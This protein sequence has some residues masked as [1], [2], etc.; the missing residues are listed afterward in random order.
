MRAAD[1]MGGGVEE[2]TRVN[3]CALVGRRAGARGRG[4]RPAL[5][6]R[7]EE[8]DA[9]LADGALS[10]LTEH[11]NAYQSEHRPVQGRARGRGH[12]KPKNGKTKKSESFTSGAVS[13]PAH[14]HCETRVERMESRGWVV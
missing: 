14:A 4:V 11:R 3:T 8:G 2:G 7:E 6:T 5:E 1:G 12:R 10:S 9:A 13:A